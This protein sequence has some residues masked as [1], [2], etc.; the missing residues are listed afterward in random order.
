VRRRVTAAGL[1]IGLLFSGSVI[2][3]K[4][5][6][7]GP[8]EGSVEV[9]SFVVVVNAINPI[10]RM[11]STVIS[12]YFFKKEEEWPNGTKVLPVDQK[13]DSKVRAMFTLAIHFKRPAAVQSY[14]QQKL[15]A[16]EEV[17]PPELATDVDVLEFVSQNPGAIGYVTGDWQLSAEVKILQITQ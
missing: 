15:F 14:W 10:D 1:L 6:W 8:P 12:D 3:A 11:S 7:E 2:A 4:Q 5:K 16:G 17:P 13:V 9:S